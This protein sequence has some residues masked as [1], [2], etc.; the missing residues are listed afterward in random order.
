[1]PMKMLIMGTMA[2]KGDQLHFPL[3]VVSKSHVGF[4][5]HIQCFCISVFQ[6]QADFRWIIFR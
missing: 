2:I 3:E 6:C 5:N 4:L 1:M